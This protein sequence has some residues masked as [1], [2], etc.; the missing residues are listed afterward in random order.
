MRSMCG[1][2]IK[3]FGDNVFEASVSVKMDNEIV[4][5]NA[6]PI[7]EVTMLSENLRL[8]DQAMYISR[9]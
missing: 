9:S 3:L 4:R 2:P 6:T 5:P 7:V 1:C 8:T